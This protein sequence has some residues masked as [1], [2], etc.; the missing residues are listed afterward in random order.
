M[1]GAGI[2]GALAAFEL[3]RAGARVIVV[4]RRAPASGSTAASTALVQYEL[5]RTL[6]SLTGLRGAEHA[7]GAYL[8]AA[9]GV[10]DLAR[11]AR[12]LGTEC[13]LV[14]HPSLYLAVDPSDTDRL[15]EEV[16][17]RRAVGLSSRYLDRGVLLSR[18]GID[19]PG[20]IL[21]EPA[22]EVN[23]VKLTRA[24]LLAMVREGGRLY[25]RTTVDLAGVCRGR[26][27]FELSTSGGPSITTEWV[28]LATGY[29][30][31]EQFAAVAE[32]T[33]LKSTY[34]LATEPLPGDPWPERALIW[35]CGEPYFYARTTADG[36]VLMG[37]EDAAFVDPEARDARLGAKCESLRAK[38]RSLFP[39]LDSRP[40][41]RWA[42]T[43][44]QTSD[45]LPYIG[46][47]AKWSHALFA[48]GYGGN[49]IT[50][51]MIAAR[52]MAGVIGGRPHP[53][54]CWFSFER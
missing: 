17:A 21:S 20:A 47:H 45:G 19:R 11:L 54:A 29:E 1:V 7:R 3:S 49:G 37:G 23:P 5:D 35:E 18:F 30:A 42:A 33:Q 28:V 48:L 9:R 13:E 2:T 51:S 53:D 25:E 38:A 43:F 41:A 46:R 8:A 32:L 44:A 50:F 16:E 36:S 24:L 27:P 31:P 6:V 4:D 10:D 15:L 39:H 22:H 12:E 40:R 26:A 14:R 34:A 52:V